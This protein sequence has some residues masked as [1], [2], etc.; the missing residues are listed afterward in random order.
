MPATLAQL[1]RNRA[2]VII[3]DEDGDH[4][5]VD[6]RPGAITP[7]T[8]QAAQRFQGADFEALSAD[9]KAEAL[10]AMPRMLA[11][12]MLGWD[13][14]DNDG[15]PIPPTLEGLQ[16]VDYAVQSLI[17][18]AITDHQRLGEQTGAKSL[19][20]SASTSRHEAKPATSRHRSRSS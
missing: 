7:R 10:S 16:D 19:T 2:R 11:S 14:L 15:H 13:L 8:I 4:I 18:Q 5:Y 17:L 1:A 3:G 6:Y 20:P 9:D 12:A